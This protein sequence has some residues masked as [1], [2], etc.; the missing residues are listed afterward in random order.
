MQRTIEVDRN[1][2]LPLIGDVAIADL[3][4][5]GWFGVGL[6]GVVVLLVAFATFHT[7][8][9]AP[10]GP[11]RARLGRLLAR[12]DELPPIPDRIV[13]VETID[14]LAAIAEQRGHIVLESTQERIASYLVLDGDLCY[15]FRPTG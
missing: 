5:A 1:A 10:G 4:V 9:R 3:P 13:E 6:G 15:R 12:A 2:A 14:N 7:Q 8:R 11:I